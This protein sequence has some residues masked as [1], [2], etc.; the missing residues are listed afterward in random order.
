MSKF[1]LIATSAFGIEKLVAMELEDLGMADMT[2]ENGRV[3]FGG[4]V[5]DIIR[6]NLFLRCA[7]RVLIKMNEFRAID[8]EEL[9]QGVLSIPWENFIPQNGKMHVTGKSIKSTLFSVSDCQAITKKAV[10]ESMKRKYNTEWFSEDGPVYKIEVAL[11]KDIVTI[12]IDTSGAG[13]HKRGYR[14][15]GGEAPLRETLAAAILKI[16]RWNSDRIW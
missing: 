13:L 16:S 15:V 3:S 6:C 1:N 8:F 11:L 5:N 2:I 10:I 4:D 14:L 9:Y 7:D 12:T